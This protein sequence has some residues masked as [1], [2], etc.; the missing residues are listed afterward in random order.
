[1]L[2]SWLRKA[3]AWELAAW[4]CPLEW[5]HHRCRTRDEAEQYRCPTG[6][7]P[8]Q[9]A[10]LGRE[11]LTDGRWYVYWWDASH[12]VLTGLG[13]PTERDVKDRIDALHDHPQELESE[14][15]PPV[16]QRCLSWVEAH[17]LL[18]RPWQGEVPRWCWDDQSAH[19]VTADREDE[20]TA[21]SKW[22]RKPLF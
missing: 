15:L 20:A 10:W 17:Q 21:R 7:R 8:G 16:A 4:C 5:V 12:T 18:G 14:N 9:V 13:R 6:C 19:F 2:E 3:G 1:M 11:Y 22:P